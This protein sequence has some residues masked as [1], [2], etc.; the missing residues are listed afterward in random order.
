MA[1]SSS[2]TTLEVISKTRVILQGYVKG[3]AA[4]SIETGCYHR[5]SH[6]SQFTN[7]KMIFGLFLPS[8][9]NNHINANTPVLFW[10][11]GLTCDD[12]NFAMKAGSR[13]FDIAEQHGIA[14]IMPDTSPRSD[15]NNDVPNVDS[16]DMG[17]GA[18]FYIN[19]TEEPYKKHYHMYDY[20]TKELPGILANNLNIGKDGAKSIT[21]HSMGGHGALSIA[22]R[23]GKYCWK[24]TSAFS[25]ICNPTECPW[26]KKAFEGYL[27]SL[28]AGEAHD[29]TCLI[30]KGEHSYDDIL[31]DQ[32]TADNF[33]EEQLK[34]EVLVDAAKKTG[35]KLSV[36]MREGFD[37][38]YYF[39]AQF[40]ES[41]VHFHAKYL[42][43]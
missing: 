40:I 35:Q 32:G 12:T 19:A 25:P 2:T 3:C 15:D 34:A 7:T 39:I 37:H 23:E 18:G 16:Y 29:A 27:G 21:G 14:I 6:Q 24:S 33:L 5:I 31:I 4:S 26:G 17:V 20:I 43:A 36:N 28:D 9:Y 1:L 30:L 38:S 8:N 42:K 41:H 11:S 10:L 22:L 13:A